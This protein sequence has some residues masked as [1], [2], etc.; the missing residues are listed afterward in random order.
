MSSGFAPRP[1]PA[2]AG[3]M[4]PGVIA[5]DDLGVGVGDRAFEVGVV[6][7]YRGWP[8]VSVLVPPAR[9]LEAE[10]PAPGVPLREW[11]A[12]QPLLV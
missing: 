4:M 3:A 8:V 1:N 2:I 6:D 5:L 7:G 9:P 11:Q 12:E 10:P